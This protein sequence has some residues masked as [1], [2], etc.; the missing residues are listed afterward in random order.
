MKPKLLLVLLEYTHV[1]PFSEIEINIIL[2][3]L[4]SDKLPWYWINCT[5]T[6]IHFQRQG[7][8]TKQIDLPSAILQDEATVVPDTQEEESRLNVSAEQKSPNLTKKQLNFPCPNRNQ[9]EKIDHLWPV[10][11]KFHVKLNR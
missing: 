4:V 6:C 9:K 3:L 7:P 8:K 11:H 5:R 10:G 1:N 2:Y